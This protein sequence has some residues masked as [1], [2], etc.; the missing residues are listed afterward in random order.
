[1]DRGKNLGNTSLGKIIKG[2]VGR[3]P[4]KEKVRLNSQ[5]WKEESMGDFKKPIFFEGGML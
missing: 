3:R 4:L 1:M 5:N 2:G